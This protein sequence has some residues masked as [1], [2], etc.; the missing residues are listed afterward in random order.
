RH[1]TCSFGDRLTVTG[2]A[3]F[4]NFTRWLALPG[5]SPGRNRFVFVRVPRVSSLSKVLANRLTSGLDGLRGS[6]LG[7]A[8]L[9]TDALR[10]LVRVL[11]ILDDDLRDLSEVGEALLQHVVENVDAPL[12]LGLHLLMRL[13]PALPRRRCSSAV[14]AARR[15]RGRTCRSRRR[16]CRRVRVRPR[17]TESCRGS[18]SRGAG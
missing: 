16:P 10:R 17:R 13:C 2:F 11:V 4:G 15:A 5:W 7:Q 14:A 18:S 6:L 8:H 9:L 1:A 3:P 12:E